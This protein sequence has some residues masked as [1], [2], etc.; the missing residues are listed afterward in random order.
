MRFQAAQCITADQ[1]SCLNNAVTNYGCSSDKSLQIKGGEEDNVRAHYIQTLGARFQTS[2]N[3]FCPEARLN[4]H[5]EVYKESGAGELP[6]SPGTEHPEGLG[7]PEGL[8]YSNE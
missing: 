2:G 7:L 8:L 6:T 1:T 5:P 4:A 3:I